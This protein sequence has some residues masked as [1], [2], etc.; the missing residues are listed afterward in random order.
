MTAYFARLSS[1]S[2]QTLLAFLVLLLLLLYPVHLLRSWSRQVRHNQEGVHL[3]ALTLAVMQYAQDHGGCLPP[4]Q[5]LPAFQAAV[6]PYTRSPEAFHPHEVPAV[7]FLP[8]PH[9]SGRRLSSLHL[10]TVLL[11]ESVPSPADHSRWV[12]FLPVPP[13]SPPF[14]DP[15]FTGLRLVREREWQALRAANSIP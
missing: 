1:G 8:N 10:P 4:M 6:L 2:K 14:G 7:L 9:L 15:D 13:G 3:N 11:Y 12:A 5:P